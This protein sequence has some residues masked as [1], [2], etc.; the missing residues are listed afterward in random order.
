[1]MESLSIGFVW[2][3][4]DKVFNHFHHYHINVDDFMW[5]FDRL[6]S[7]YVCMS[8]EAH[9]RMTIFPFFFSIRF[10]LVVLDPFILNRM[11]L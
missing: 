3:V 10:S 7:V 6:P 9:N 11:A 8:A 4:S 5:M 1:M 2:A